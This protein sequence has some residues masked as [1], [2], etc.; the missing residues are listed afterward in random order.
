MNVPVIKQRRK[1]INSE[2]LK[3]VK[4]GAVL[5]NFARES[6]VDAQAVVDSLDQG[7]LGRYIC[8]FPE[9]CLLSRPDVY[10]MPHIGASTQEAEENGAVMVAGQL[11]DYLENGNIKNCVN[12]RNVSMERNA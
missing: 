2:S 7:Q 12:F 6:V 10:A 9:P 8:D 5:L 11:M 3:G 1:M 4:T